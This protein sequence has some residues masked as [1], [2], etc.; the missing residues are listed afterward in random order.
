MSR[1]ILVVFFIATC[2][3]S[4]GQ[5]YK[6]EHCLFNT[7]LDELS[8]FFL[9][10]NLYFSSN[11][12]YDTKKK[13][14]PKKIRLKRSKH[15]ILAEDHDL[16]SAIVHV[17]DFKGNNNIFSFAFREKTDVGYFTV[18]KNLKSYPR[19]PN[20]SIYLSQF[21]NGEW[22]E[23]TSLKYNSNF[24][25]LANPTFSADG[26]VIYFESDMPG[27][28]GGLD[29][30]Y[31]LWEENNWSTPV[32]LGSTVNSEANEKTP[33]MD[34]SNVLYFSS[35]RDKRRRGFDIYSFDFNS[36]MLG[37]LPE[38]LNSKKNDLGYIHL[39]NP[40][41]GYF[42]SDRD[43]MGYDV[44]KFSYPLPE[45]PILLE[46]K[47]SQKCF[48]FIDPEPFHDSLK[49]KYV[50]DFGDGKKGNNTATRHCFG[51]PGEYL[52]SL[53]IKD[54]RHPEMKQ[55]VGSK[56]LTIEENSQYFFNNVS[57]ND[58]NGSTIRLSVKPELIN[59]HVVWEVNSKLVTHGPIF[60]FT[61]SLGYGQHIVKAHFTKDTN[62][63]ALI[64]TLVFLPENISDLKMKRIRLA[65]AQDQVMINDQGMAILKDIFSNKLSG[66][67]ELL[68]SS[69]FKM[70]DLTSLQ[71]QM[72]PYNVSISTKIVEGMVS[73]FIEIYYE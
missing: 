46:S 20:T 31:C 4:Y 41:E 66:K 22:L 67:G 70:N 51:K 49:L 47:V 57:M 12:K 64:D 54:T 26:S 61:E 25:N 33:F 60:S 32:N 11:N 6:I 18:S 16:D 65:L 21:K 1:L 63:Y 38:P 2:L 72:L 30:W 56:K 50:W 5:E 15:R 53:T 27:G 68:I 45:N 59:N 24:Y 37:H 17:Y 71:N 69:N 7:H 42:S 3:F 40:F 9:N 39:G 35:D 36:K 34:N 58:T 19:S 43:D 10:N 28:F 55:T 48:S 14:D 8:P 73:P 23:M 62:H 52:V 29:I 44:F 13:Y